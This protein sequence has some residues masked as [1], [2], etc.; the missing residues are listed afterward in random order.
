[1]RLT[2]FFAS[3]RCYSE[4]GASASRVRAPS[5]G[6]QTAAII[7]LIG[8]GRAG[9]VEYVIKRGRVDVLAPGAGG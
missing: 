3:R 8:D 5:K 9:E 6:R 7:R 2:G 4:H 1:M